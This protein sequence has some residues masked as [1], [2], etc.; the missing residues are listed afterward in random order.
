MDQDEVEEVS[1]RDEAARLNRNSE[2]IAMLRVHISQLTKADLCMNFS[3]ATFFDSLI[4]DIAHVERGK[5]KR[6]EE[7]ERGF[8]SFVRCAERPCATREGY[9]E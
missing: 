6:R 3:C 7:G 1:G 2:R 4:A 8:C 5:C 9:D